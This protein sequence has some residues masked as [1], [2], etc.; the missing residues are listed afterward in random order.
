[1]GNKQENNNENLGKFNMQISLNRFNFFPGETI[2]GLIE[3][4]P[5][6]EYLNDF[7][8][9]KD[10][11]LYYALL[12]KECWKSNIAISRDKTKETNSI[13]INDDSEINNY[14]TDMI[15]SKKEVY[16]N[17]NEKNP[18]NNI[19]I[20][21]QIKIPLETKHS[22]EFVRP[23]KI[24]DIYGYSRIYLDIE[25]PDSFN[26]KEILIFIQ[27]QPTP[28]KSELTI[29]KYIT[30]KK[31]GFLGSGSNINFQGS[32]PKNY[33]GFNE[34]CPLKISLDIFGS[35]DNVNGIELTLKRKVSFLKNNSKISE[36]YI[37]DLWQ[38]NMKENTLKNN[39]N[40][41]LQL[42]ESDKL[43]KEKKSSFFDVNSVSKENLICLLPSYEGNLI[44]CSYFILIKVFYDSMLITNPEFEMPINLGHTKTIFNQTSML[45]INK[46]LGKINETM[47]SS[48]IDDSNNEIINNKKEVDIKSKMKDIFGESSQKNKIKQE[49]MNKIFGNTP[50]KNINIKKNEETPLPPISN[51]INN[52]NF[53]NVNINGSDSIDLPSKEEIYTPKDEQPA[54]ELNKDPLIK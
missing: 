6:D 23:N 19:M 4:S 18:K 52:N 37:D 47:I 20:P 9:L 24:S 42:R 38:V 14:K 53:S 22:F 48:L 49:N 34:I 29:S 46:I 15:I 8:I 1:M 39:I 16:N 2:K 5:K 36:E 41:N 44:K 35:N 13:N 17:N 21:F 7:T 45:D 51:N 54:P 32:Y 31:L 28:L 43:I 27:K 40:F 26:K 50:N 30:K 12:H 33:Y 11:K 3:L 10:I 25:I